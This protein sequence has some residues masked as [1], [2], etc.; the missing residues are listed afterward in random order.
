MKSLCQGTLTI[1]FKKKIFCA[2]FYGI[3]FKQHIA[4]VRALFDSCVW[5][6]VLVFFKD[7][8]FDIYKLFIRAFNRLMGV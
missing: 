5:V 3:A 4:F 2:N 6:W 1:Q 7:N 8:I